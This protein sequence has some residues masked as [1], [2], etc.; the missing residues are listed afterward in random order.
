MKGDRYDPD[1]LYGDG[2]PPGVLRADAPRLALVTNL[3]HLVSKTRPGEERPWDAA[4]VEAVL[5]PTLP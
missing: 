5:T 2:P 4:E 3:G 1:S